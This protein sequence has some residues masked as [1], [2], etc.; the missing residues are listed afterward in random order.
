M[1]IKR[2]ILGIIINL[3]LIL[4][5]VPL[6]FAATTFGFDGTPTITYCNTELLGIDIHHFAD[7]EPDETFTWRTGFNGDQLTEGSGGTFDFDY[8]GWEVHEYSSASY[9]YTVYGTQSLVVD[10]VEVEIWRWDAICTGLNTGTVTYGRI[11][12]RRA[13]SDS[14]E[15]RQIFFDGRINSYDT[16]N[17]VVLFGKPDADDAWRLEVYN[18]DATGMLFVV[19]PETIAAVAECPESNTLIQSDEATGI[20]LWRLPQR[21]VTVEGVRVCPFQLNAPS[22]EAGKTYVIIFDTLFPNSYYESGDEWI[23]N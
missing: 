23:G 20:S 8:V 15:S 16:G 6:T 17:S 1:S 5:T 2:M 10:G 13:V 19:Y 9:P 7:L 21:T 22:T 18:A 3:T 11:F 14:S 4:I 12:V